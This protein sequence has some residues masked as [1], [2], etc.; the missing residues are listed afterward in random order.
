MDFG[1]AIY[2]IWYSGPR[3]AETGRKWR[4]VNALT[5]LYFFFFEINGGLRIFAVSIIFNYMNY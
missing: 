5:F 4:K 2:I 1:R 3:C